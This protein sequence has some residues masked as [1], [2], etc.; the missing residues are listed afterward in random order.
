MQSSKIFI[1]KKPSTKISNVC[2]TFKIN[3]LC[4]LYKYL[5]HCNRHLY[6]NN[7]AATYSP[8]R[9]QYSTIGRLSLNHRVRD[10]ME[11]KF[12]GCLP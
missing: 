1:A 8:Y 4:T 3:A 2:L 7:P 5:S 9:L 6:F 10:V 11:L 12:H